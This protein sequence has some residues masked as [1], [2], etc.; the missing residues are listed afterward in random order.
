[1]KKAFARYDIARQL[2]TPMPDV[3]SVAR[4]GD[5]PGARCNHSQDLIYVGGRPCIVLVAGESEKYVFDDVYLY[6]IVDNQWI[7]VLRDDQCMSH[8]TPRGSHTTV[9]WNNNVYLF[10]GRNR[11]SGSTFNDTWRLQFLD[12]RPPIE[13]ASENKPLRYTWHGLE[14]KGELPEARCHATSVLRGDHMVI[15]GGLAV[16]DSIFSDIYALDLNL[17]TWSQ[18][19][20]LAQSLDP[21][22]LYGHTTVLV[23]G[24]QSMLVFGG[25]SSAN[26][27]IDSDKLYRFI[28]GSDTIGQWSVVPVGRSCPPMRYMAAAV[29]QDYVILFGGKQAYTAQ[30]NDMWSVDLMD[31]DFLPS[32]PRTGPAPWEAAPVTGSA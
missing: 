14:C 4:P 10:G 30:F 28:W 6:S 15:Y 31:L 29:H 1:M 16:A 3:D 9:V 32:G 25:R 23:D 11:F 22:F 18:T 19:K 7:P 21:P 17:C 24:E 8:P 13:A 2:W 20:V 26:A 27:A 12:D 5:C